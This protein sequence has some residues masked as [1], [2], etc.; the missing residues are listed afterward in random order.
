MTSH[1][2]SRATF[3]QIDA[4]VDSFELILRGFGIKVVPGSLLER[5]CLL[6]KDLQS[7]RDTARRGAYVPWLNIQTDL[8]LAM[9]VLNL[10]Q[11]TLERQR[12]PDFT[13]IVPH[14][15]LL[16]AGMPAQTA[17]A[18]IADDAS[19]KIFELRLALAC[20]GAGTN[21]TM[22][23]P[24]SSSGGNNPDIICR[25]ADGRRWGF[26]CKVIHGTSPITCAERFFDGVEQIERST[27]DTGLVVLSFKNR[28]PHDKILPQLGTTQS[29]DA[30]LGAHPSLDRLITSVANDVGAHI[31]AMAMAATDLELAGSLKGKKAL[32][33]VASPIDF[34]ALLKDRGQTVVSTVS[35]I[36]IVHLNHLR[37]PNAFDEAAAAVTD[38]L[39]HALA[40]RETESR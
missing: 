9:G 30:I 7:R 19:N 14:L 11:L 4:A 6:L 20:L 35:F 16:N 34:V 33:A 22:D 26:A 36:R 25:M 40:L 13:Q 2:P 8:R 3:E 28:L 32:T 27:A 5:A 1:D 21:L 38:D 15:R 29:Q 39:N 17:R 23:D 12:H 24:V 31:S 10:I 18:S 37:L